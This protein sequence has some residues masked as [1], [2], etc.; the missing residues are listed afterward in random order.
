[1]N[2]LIRKISIAVL[3]SLVAAS[4]ASAEEV[5]KLTYIE[6]KV[7]VLKSA[8]TEAAQATAGQNIS[9]G[10]IIRTKGLSKAEIQFRDRTILRL[11]ES[12]RVEIKEY[13]IEDGKRINAL[14]SLE[15]GGI[16]VIA[17][18]ASGKDNLRIE[19]PNASG[20][21]KGT[22]LFVIYQKSATS[23]LVVDGKFSVANLA[24]PEKTVEVTGGN[25][26]V[27]PADE[28]PLPQRAYLALEKSGYERA[29]EPAPKS[30]D[31]GVPKS[32]EGYSEPG[33]MKAVVTKV[34]G[35]VR[36]RNRGSIT[37]HD[38]KVNEVL[39]TGDTIESKDDGNIEIKLDNNNV[40]NIKPNSQLILQKL[41]QDLDSGDYENLLESNFG[42][43]RAKVNKLKDNSKFEIKTPTAIAAVRGTILYLNILPNLTTAYFENGNG[44]VQN[45]I[46]GVIQNVA[47]GNSSSSDDQG[48]VSL[49]A[50]PSDEQRSEW[51]EG[52]EAE[53][54]AEGYSAPE[55]ASPENTGEEGE[56]NDLGS[57]G[58]NLIPNNSP[59]NN[60]PIY[61]PPE[62]E[63]NQSPNPD[64]NPPLS[65]TTPELVNLSSTVTGNFGHYG[66]FTVDE[67]SSVSISLTSNLV[68]PELTEPQEE[69]ATLPVTVSGTYSNPNSRMLWW[70][71]A[72]GSDVNGANLLGWAGGTWHSWDG[73]V[74]SIY[75]DSSG[76]AGNVFGYVSGTND[77]TTGTLTGGGDLFVIPMSKTD[78][79]PSD[80]S[81]SI[82]VEDAKS[83]N[84]YVSFDGGYIDSQFS[85]ETKRIDEEDW[86]IWREIYSGSYNRPDG[87]QN[88]VGAEGGDYN[89]GGYYLS[90]VEG[91]DNLSG[92]LRMDA[93]G[94]Y[95]DYTKLGI[96]Y[97]TVLGGYK[98]GEVYD[99]EGIGLGAFVEEA[100]ALSGY[101]N[102]DSLYYNDGGYISHAGEEYGLIGAA[103][104]PWEG[105][106]EFYAMGRYGYDGEVSESDPK[107]LNTPMYSYNVNE[108]NYTTIDGGAFYGF[109]AGLWNNR[110]LN[111][112]AVAIYLDPEGG[113]GL[114]D[115]YFSGDYYPGVGP[116]TYYEDSGMWSVTGTLPATYLTEGLNIN[117]ADLYSSVTNSYLSATIDGDF[118]GNGTISGGVSYDSEGNP[119]G[120][121]YFIVEG[122]G[123]GRSWGIYNL[124]LGDENYYYD[125]D[126]SKIWAAT[127][128]GSGQFGY[129]SSQGIMRGN[130]YGVYDE[131]YGEGD[132]YWIATSIGTWRSKADY[133]ATEDPNGNYYGFVGGIWDNETIAGKMVALYSQPGAIF[134]YDG[135]SFSG[136][137]LTG[138]NDIGNIMATNIDGV[139][140][141]AGEPWGIWK[142]NVE[143]NYNAPI[144]A[145]FKLTVGGGPNSEGYWLGI[146]AGIKR[147]ESDIITGGFRGIWLDAEEV[148]GSL[149]WGDIIGNAGTDGQWE[150]VGLGEWET[151]VWRENNFV[152][153]NDLND[154]LANYIERDTITGGADF[155][156]FNGSGSI[157][158]LNFN[159][160]SLELKDQEWGVYYLSLD[161]TYD[162]PLVQTTWSNVMGGLDSA[163]DIND[164]G[165]WLVHNS[166]TWKDGVIRAGTYGY[167]LWYPLTSN[168]LDHAS[169]SLIE[170]DL[171]GVSNDTGNGS[172]TWS[173]TGVG[174]WIEKPLA[175][176]GIYDFSPAENGF[177]YWDAN[178]KELVFD[179]ASS[180]KGLLGG[181]EPF[182][183]EF[184]VGPSSFVSI[185]QYSNPNN[186]KLIGAEFNG[187]TSEGGR[188]LGVLGGTSLN[189]IFEGALVALYIRPIEGGYRAGYI[190]NSWEDDEHYV[191]GNLYP[192][193]GMFE[194][195]EQSL[196]AYL[197]RITTITPDELYYESPSLKTDDF[198]GAGF[199]DIP[200]VITGF[201]GTI[202][203]ESIGLKDEH[204][205]IW[206]AGLGGTFN[207]IGE[208]PYNWRLAFGGM[209]DTQQND[210]GWFVTVKGNEWNDGRFD[211][212]VK[213]V[214]LDSRVIGKS[215]VFVATK[216]TGRVFGTYEEVDTTWQ[217]VG[218]GAWVE[219][220]ELDPSIVGFDVTELTQMVSVP[221]TE[222]YSSLLQGA[223]GFGPQ[224]D[225]GSITATMDISFYASAA[226]ALNGIWAALINGNYTGPTD[227][228]WTLTLNDAS[229]TN[230]TLTGTHWSDGQW[231]ANV[232]GTA[233]DNVNFSG[234][235]GGTYAQPDPSTGQ[236]TLEGAGAGTWTQ[237]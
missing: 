77:D 53:G 155:G 181:T 74:S 38:A 30:A 196:T 28:S 159:G 71:D 210:G 154:F 13:T 11:S 235:A 198:G 61:N 22:D 84:R 8:Q 150:G 14:L 92:S 69:P 219:V 224:A 200:G 44:T 78:I 160:E 36:I 85:R 95:L 82:V 32:A 166:G 104:S 165:Y 2:R 179:T 169:L 80:L 83:G 93:F 191:D 225:V 142:F 140:P 134:D 139:D 135:S 102:N 111:G 199:M 70:G 194:I 51:Q 130:L 138:F 90:V 234:Q 58:N 132:G 7:D 157:D 88:W 177:A 213:G 29:T 136:S 43:I 163:S 16:R 17:S 211:G 176:G 91:T 63:P 156:N 143:G 125:P 197:D 201:S 57:E 184:G 137:G 208:Q 195:E 217:A 65:E 216:I 164:R 144:T 190:I 34:R 173:A 118:G 229:G 26:T 94:F 203:G 221:I 158:T 175:F 75:I 115:G 131:Y 100:L 105:G 101:W 222:I 188:L 60:P 54:G 110:S 72:T 230:A 15:R 119:E 49:P 64:D 236:G 107:I 231:H 42:K 232:N 9:I 31:A 86:G 171:F 141:D 109:T 146:I 223:G 183:A 113:A 33:E 67:E 153:P 47:A 1:M 151:Q 121:T 228:N 182:W 89:D 192:G 96:Y 73:F 12:S 152:A 193:I 79:S 23:L 168:S 98:P 24:L 123:K 46:S 124:K 220:A 10:D 128:E 214:G 147:P 19:T 50:P 40:I 20:V 127:I 204:W 186:H 133:G 27:I 212:Y 237:Q 45:I 120:K 116:D 66:S 215:E 202:T 48:N 227:N 56:G 167:S 97:G 189:D 3:L 161:G 180:F 112:S 233:P 68:L 145:P 172:G 4:S 129:N 35:D 6:G 59:N 206:R 114:L 21:V 99:F 226:D 18:K 103:V 76:T 207:N 117:P 126:G 149:Y 187:T 148:H 5:G 205:G 39:S 178:S 174:S 185:G 87:L 106:V 108:E 209:D 55:G 62:P 162:N 170:G 41:T 122:T 25:T 37:W 81:A 218:A 52:W